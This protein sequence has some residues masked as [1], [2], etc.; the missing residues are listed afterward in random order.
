MDYPDFADA[1]T[2]EGDTDGEYL[3]DDDREPLHSLDR[4]SCPDRRSDIEDFSAQADIDIDDPSISLDG[5]GDDDESGPLPS[6]PTENLGGV[7][8]NDP[9]WFRKR[10]NDHWVVPNVFLRGALFAGVRATQK[11]LKNTLIQTQGNFTIIASGKQLNQSDLDV[12][13][14]VVNLEKGNTVSVSCHALL[15]HLNR[16]DGSS[17]RAWLI[18]ALQ[19]LHSCYVEITFKDGRRGYAGTLIKLELRPNAS[20]D[21]RPRG[22]CRISSE[23]THLISSEWDHPISG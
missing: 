3:L 13:C 22:R 2:G 20:N 10:W 8:P 11:T 6:E 19:R 1:A 18:S 7:P 4:Y 16:H 9:P 23:W 5:E 14:A 21:P 17:D 15:R 12:W